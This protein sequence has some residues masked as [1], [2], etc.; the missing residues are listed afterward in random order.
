ML[1]R[2]KTD[3]QMHIKWTLTSTQIT[4]FNDEFKTSQ[5]VF[6]VHRVKIHET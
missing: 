5:E 2:D 6:Q 3:G 4:T 1:L